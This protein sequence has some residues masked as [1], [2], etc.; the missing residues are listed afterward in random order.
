MQTRKILFPTDLGEVS[1]EALDM[2]TGMARDRGAT[3]LIL[4]VGQSIPI[5]A[6]ESYFCMA[7]P[8]VDRL[9]GE[10]QHIRPTD[11][12]VPCEHRVET[13][14]TI[15]A[16]IHVAKQED[17]ELIV[18]ATHGRQGLSRF[19]MGSVAEEVLRRAPCPVLTVKHHVDEPVLV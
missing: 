4:H 1:P 14:D 9:L 12:S 18:M 3:L 11:P 7:E 17:C 2:A 13:G 5:A 15:A 8:N 16:I 19:F 6:G 10:L